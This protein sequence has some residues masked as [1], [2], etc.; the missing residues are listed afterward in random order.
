MDVADIPRYETS[1]LGRFA[2]SPSAM[3]RN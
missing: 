2:T 3:A 1:P